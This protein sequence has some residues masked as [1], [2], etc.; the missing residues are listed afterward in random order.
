MTLDDLKALKR[1]DRVVCSPDGFPS[2]YPGV[3]NA[4]DVRSVEIFWRDGTSSVIWFA[5]CNLSDGRAPR[6]DFLHRR[7]K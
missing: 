6:L 5:H 1:G 4:I 7:G 3:V 2:G